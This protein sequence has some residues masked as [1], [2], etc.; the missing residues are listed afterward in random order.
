[1]HVQIPGFT[2]PN[3]VSA[4]QCYFILQ[5]IIFLLNQYFHKL[6]IAGKIISK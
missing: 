1:M 4:I 3:A 6:E 5:L 2:K